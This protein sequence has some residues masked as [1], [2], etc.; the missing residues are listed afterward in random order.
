MKK[1]FK[2]TCMF[3]CLLFLGIV[4]TACG[5][6]G[7]GSTGGGGFAYFPT[8]NTSDNSVNNPSNTGNSGDNTGNSGDTTPNPFANAKVG[9]AV[10]MGQY[11]YTENGN[12]N[13]YS[14]RWKVLTKDEENSRLLVVSISGIK[15][16]SLADTSTAYIYNSAI[17]QW[18]NGDFYNNTFTDDEKSFI[19]S[20]RYN[21]KVFLLSKPEAEQYFANNTARKCRL[22]NYNINAANEGYSNWWLC[23]PYYNNY[24]QSI[25]GVNYDGNIVGLSFYPANNSN[26]SPNSYIVRPAMWVNI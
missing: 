15:K 12:N 4:L 13:I 2:F 19:A 5:G 23:S 16:M 7:G 3:L 1:I 25:W 22:F 20:V 9:D 14:I 21:S 18:L 26:N 24:T 8:T 6:G 10:T 17:Y 11:H